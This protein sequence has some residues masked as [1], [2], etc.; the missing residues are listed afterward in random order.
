MATCLRG[1]SITTPFD[2]MRPLSLPLDQRWHVHGAIDLAGG[3]GIIRAPTEGETRGFLIVRGVD[4]KSGPRA[5]GPKSREKKEVYD[6]PWR[7]YWEDIYGAFF[8]LIEKKT[9]RL[10]IMTHVYPT[11]ILNRQVSPLH[12]PCVYD[13]Y[14][15]ERSDSRYPCRIFK[16]TKVVVREGQ[17]LS[18][19]G[20]AGF[21]SGAHVHWEVHHQH[22]RLD[23]YA[24]R[25]DPSKE[26]M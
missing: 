3:D 24:E 15:E 8:V 18:K 12:Y 14:I 6:L 16:T 19:V 1:G 10:H 13:G 26:Y 20:N 11:M 17:P 9:G 23:D 7:E 4:P 21:S 22:T 2:E 5:W 25:I